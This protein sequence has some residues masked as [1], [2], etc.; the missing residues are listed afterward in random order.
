M[1]KTIAIFLFFGLAVT[2][3]TVAQT[4]DCL[5]AIV[6][7]QA[8]TLTDLRIAREFGFFDREAADRTGE[9]Q[10]AVLDALIDQKIVLEVAREPVIIS[11]DELDLSLEALRDRLGPGTLERKL[12]AFGLTEKDLYP[13][14]ADKIRYEKVVSNRFNLTLPVARADVEQYYHDVYVPEQKAQG[15]A[16]QAFEKALPELENR[17]RE[18]LRTKKVSAWV[19]SL[20]SQAEVRINKD[21]LTGGKEDEP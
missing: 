4:V 19:K 21:C 20:R 14:L 12:Q 10:L 3:P 9:P 2:A 7:G 11:G 1:K 5:V 18:K 13:F 16:P 17:L 6:N 15:L 8:V